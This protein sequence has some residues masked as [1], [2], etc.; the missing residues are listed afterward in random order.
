M[1]RI[2]TDL[3][4][5]AV[6]YEDL[7]PAEVASVQ[8]TCAEMAQA[9]ADHD[10]KDADRVAALQQLKAKGKTDQNL[11]LVARAL[12]IDPNAPDPARAG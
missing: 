9:Q 11:A 3:A 12:G 5:G 10:A 1:K 6:T 4:T 2:M 8:A 7:T